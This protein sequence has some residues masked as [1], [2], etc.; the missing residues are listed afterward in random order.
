[1]TAG[2]QTISGQKT[3]S[4][5]TP[6]TSSSTGAVIISGTGGLGVGGAIYSGGNINA[7]GSLTAGGV[8]LANITASIQAL[9]SSTSSQVQR[10][11][12][13][14]GSP[15]TTTFTANSNPLEIT[16]QDKVTTTDNSSTT[17]HTFTL[18]ASMVYHFTV[19]VVARRTGGSSGTAEDGASYVIN[20][21]FHVVGGNATRIGSLN[22]ISN[23][24]QPAWS[25]T[26]T[27]SSGNVLVTVSGANNNN[28]S[29]AMTA[30][31]YPINA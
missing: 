30:R 19:T 9:N 22:I 11:E 27:T 17:L 25:A 8:A 24:N 10:I 13:T 1:M 20:G 15:G 16:V 31:V 7:G 18:T 23:E 5:S 2:T 28:V 21:T 14:A 29:W 26:L 6:S 3:F 12:T 4:N